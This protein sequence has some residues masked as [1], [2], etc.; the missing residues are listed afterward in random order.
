[1][2][3]AAM[4]NEERFG[5]MR[6]GTDYTLTLP[7]TT[8]AVS[9]GWKVVPRC[10]SPRCVRR[11]MEIEDEILSVFLKPPVNPFTYLFIMPGFGIGV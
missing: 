9:V 6:K 10:I 2:D 8:P 7:M 1:M 3:L 11:A 4:T 5:W